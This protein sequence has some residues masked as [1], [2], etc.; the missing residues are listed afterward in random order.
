MSSGLGHDVVV[1]GEHHR[2]PGR[3]QLGRMP[4][5]PLD[6]GELVVELRPGLRIAVRRVERGDEHAATA[7]SM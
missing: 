5:Q 6:P 2:Q 1:A 3:E 7:A 4:M